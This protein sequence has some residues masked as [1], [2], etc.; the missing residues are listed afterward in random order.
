MIDWGTHFARVAQRPTDLSVRLEVADLVEER[1]PS[2]AEFIRNGVALSGLAL[3]DPARR[4]RGRT[5]RI[6]LRQGVRKIL[7]EPHAD[8]I[9]GGHV[10]GGWLEGGTVDTAAFMREAESRFA[11]L[12]LLH[13][14]LSDL[15]DRLDALLDAPWLPRLRSL[16]LPGA[17]LS[18][19]DAKRMAGSPALRGIRYLGLGHS[20]IGLEG[21][22]AFAASPHLGALQR[23]ELGPDAPRHE[24]EPWSDQGAVIG[25]DVCPTAD[26][27][28]RMYGSRPWLNR[29]D[30]HPA[31]RTAL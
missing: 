8:W 27:L 22:E 17:A 23:L 4:E 9:R 20:D 31:F 7:I 28:E 16:A 26:R 18:D 10:H 6:L 2:F 11:V 1:A 14:D 12:P 29:A 24:R 19:G 15:G 5:E 21:L 3:G 25:F 30:E 13:L